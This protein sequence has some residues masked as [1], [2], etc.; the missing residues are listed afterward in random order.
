MPVQLASR[1]FYFPATLKI[2][3]DPTD[4]LKLLRELL[5]GA[6][7]FYT[8]LLSPNQIC[9]LVY[10]N[11]RPLSNT[12][13]LLS[14]CITLSYQTQP[15]PPPSKT[16]KTLCEPSDVICSSGQDKVNRNNTIQCDFVLSE[17]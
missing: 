2:R 6:P 15:F 14:K 3:T 11:T 8:T 4:E 12:Y 17:H 1:T 5:C 9:G 16:R 13:P 7:P 10:K